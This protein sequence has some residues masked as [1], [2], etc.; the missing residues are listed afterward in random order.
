MDTKQIID[1]IVAAIEEAPEKAQGF[2]DDPKGAV[3]KVAGG[4]P[5]DIHEVVQGVLG[6]LADSGMDLSFVDISKLDLSLFDPSKLDLG[7]L[8]SAASKL[9]ID[10]TKLDFSKLDLASA[11]SSLLG[12]FGGLFGKK[13]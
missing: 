8:Q 2:I 10:L 1:A 9:H 12:G 13:K 11:M 5:F 6:R 7:A 3:A 4:S